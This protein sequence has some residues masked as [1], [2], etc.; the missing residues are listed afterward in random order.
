VLGSAQKL[1]AQLEEGFT[2]VTQVTKF[3]EKEN[4][5]LS[6]LPIVQMQMK[7]KITRKIKMDSEKIGNNI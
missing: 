5:P 1:T 3:T 2:Q 4:P 6:H 7:T